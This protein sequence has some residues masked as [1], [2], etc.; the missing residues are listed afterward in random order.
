MGNGGTTTPAATPHRIEYS[1]TYFNKATIPHTKEEKYEWLV[2]RLFGA[3][4][5]AIKMP[6]GTTVE[7]FKE[8][9]KK[10]WHPSAK[11]DAA[12]TAELNA[13][14]PDIIEGYGD[15]LYRDL[16][17][18][19][20]TVTPDE[21]PDLR[22]HYTQGGQP[23]GKGAVGKAADPVN[24]F[25]GNFSYST[26]D[27]LIDGAGMVFNFTRSYS[28]KAS[29]NGP[30]GFKWDHNYNLWISVAPDKQ[31]LTLSEGD[32]EL[33]HFR[34]HELHDY[35]IPPD[36][37]CAVVLSAN[38]SF[39]L[40]EPD[41]NK[42]I[43]QPHDLYHPA[44]HVVSRIEDRFGNYLHFHYTNGLLS[45]VEV[46]HPQRTV[47]FFYDSIFRI[48]DIR[49]FMVRTWRYAYDDLGDLCSRNNPSYGSI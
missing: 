15:A 11:D 35:F 8:F 27:F 20:K 3:I 2:N 23:T 37:K 41:G 28:Q 31:H 42:I 9:L 48:S 30:L 7:E 22:R 39:V 24:L 14:I 19:S 36:G 44:I 16:V 29:Y 1:V 43:F 18:A 33:H 38:N 13:M 10:I 40:Q 6:E 49:D 32:L 47:S 4:G 12:L 5:D 17:W 46:N 25:D 45:Q 21:D 26:Q 34:R